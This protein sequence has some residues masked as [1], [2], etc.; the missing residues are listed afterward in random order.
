MEPKTVIDPVTFSDLKAL[1]GADVV[2]LVD[3]YNGETADLIEQL[4]RALAAG[5]AAAFRRL[6]HSIKSSSAS[7][8]ALAFSQSARELEM[9]GRSGDL[10][11]AA[12][13]VESLAAGFMRVKARL[14]ELKNEP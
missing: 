8:G 1:M 13:G 10:S 7:L 14:E 11:S 5:D 4:R 12:P 6:A 3:T 2:E 9:M